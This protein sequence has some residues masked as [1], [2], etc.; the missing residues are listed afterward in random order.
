MSSLI[1]LLSLA[2]TAWSAPFPV[3]PSLQDGCNLVHSADFTPIIEAI[4]KFRLPAQ[5]LGASPRIEFIGADGIRRTCSSSVVSDSGNLLSAGHCIDDCMAAFKQTKV[6]IGMGG[7]PELS[8]F[9]TTKNGVPSKFS[10]AGFIDGRLTTFEVLAAKYCRMLAKGRNPSS[11]MEKNCSRE[12]DFAMLRPNPALGRDTPC[13]KSSSGKDSLGKQILAIGHPNATRRARENPRARDSDGRSSYA[14]FGEVVR[15]TECQTT[16]IIPQTLDLEEVLESKT[17]HL[18]ISADIV[19]GN[20]GGG[21]VTFNPVRVIGNVS[22]SSNDAEIS[23]PGASFATSNDQ[24]RKAIR[25]QDLRAFDA[26]FACEEN[27]VEH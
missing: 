25:P 23:C 26:L 17:N 16:G 13:I 11:T 6:I 21:V 2:V 12:P 1:L 19:P 4:N 27:A 3:A 24:M 18:Q 7:D 15:K 22:S 20:S 14:S 8:A 9:D 10:C 5:I